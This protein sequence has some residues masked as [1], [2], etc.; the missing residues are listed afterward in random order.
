MLRPEE[1]LYFLHIPKTGGTSLL[2]W[3]CSLYVPRL[4]C[5]HLELAPIRDDLAQHGPRYRLYA[6]HYGVG[7]LP[8]LPARPRLITWLR[9]PV[10]RLR[11]SY[12]YLRELPDSA[13]GELL[14]HPLAIKQREAALRLPFREWV[15]LPQEEYA[16]HNLQAQH[17]S[18]EDCPPDQMFARALR[19]LAEADHFGLTE[20]MQD[21]LDLL[22]HRL[23]LPPRR[24]EHRLNPS[25]AGAA[26]EDDPGV[27]DLVLERNAVDRRLYEAG[28]EI[29]DQ[30]WRD[31]RGAFS[32]AFGRPSA[33]WWRRFGRRTSAPEDP[34][35]DDARDRLHRWL[36]ERFREVRAATAAPEAGGVSFAEPV[37]GRGWMPPI[38]LGANGGV[39]RWTGPEARS[40]LYLNVSKASAHLFSFTMRAVMDLEVITSFQLWVN[41]ERVPMACEAAPSEAF[42]YA[43]RFSGVVLASALS[44]EPGLVRVEFRISRTFPEPVASEPKLGP[45]HL[46]FCLDRLDVT[47][48]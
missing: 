37:W 6:G 9:E 41:G 42:P 3:L 21:S 1:T 7:L 2:A 33:P 26:A 18:G 48:V 15:Q 19:T 10:R 11:S 20:R 36:E 4:V 12:Y 43:H 27:A 31:L 17:L 16:L 30:R 14:V 22:C 24:L 39:V 28:I 13:V 35:A 29:F 45:K 44:R 5:P 47:P 40:L 32:D 38:D 25:R 34:S 8:L 46:G 23:V